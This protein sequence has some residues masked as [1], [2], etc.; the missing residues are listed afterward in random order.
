MSDDST[1]LAYLYQRFIHDELKSAELAEF[2]ELVRRAAAEDAIAGV[3]AEY[4]APVP[5]GVGAMV[6]WQSVEDRILREGREAGD[7]GASIGR[8]GAPVIRRWRRW[9]V[10][11][12]VLLV[13]LG[14]GWLWRVMRHPG[15]EEGPMVVAAD[16]PPGH[17]GA[18]LTLEG[19]QQVVLDSA[20]NGRI[21]RQGN[22]TVVKMDG[23]LAYQKNG[24]EAGPAISY[25]T[26]TVPRGRQFEVLLPDSTRVWLN[27]ASS[28]HFPTVFAGGERLVRLTGEAYFEVRSNARA[29]FR[30]MT[31]RQVVEVLGT[32]FNI[33]GYEDEPGVRTT[34]LTGSVQVREGVQAAVRLAPGQQALL[35]GQGHVEL[36]RVDTEDVI[37]WKEGWFRFSG[38][39]VG[40][41][42]RQLSRWYD[43]DVLYEGAVPVTRIGGDVPRSMQLSKVLDV[44]RMSGV[45]LEMRDGK[46]VVK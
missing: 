9:I 42:M 25:N 24:G 16:L 44:L 1:R 27:S 3:F 2:W 10:A 7:A 43:V 39:S 20:G 36:A 40:P 18:I 31:G 19:G 33:N 22:V 23:K 17:D 15:G 26:L 30:V 45:N 8:G 29:P 13:L 11:A 4:E 21:A 12:A 5:A 14:G 32:S 28:L 46:I 41:I 6:D 37:A 38:K 34:L 35:D